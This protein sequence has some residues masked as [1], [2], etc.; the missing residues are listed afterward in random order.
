M[1]NAKPQNPQDSALW[2]L[3]EPEY[4]VAILALMVAL[5]GLVVIVLK[6]GDTGIFTA[7]T[8]GVGTIAGAALGGAGKRRSDKRAD[9]A[10]TEAAQ[11]AAA[12][13][14]V[15]KTSDIDTAKSVATDGLEAAS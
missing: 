15:L 6:G 8:T 5:V 14:A 7:F 3:E 12:L 9:K 1:G 10:V 13:R 4:L 2:G 11:H